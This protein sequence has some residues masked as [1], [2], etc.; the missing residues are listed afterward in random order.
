MKLNVGGVD[1]IL[2]V[3]LGVVLIAATV[4]GAL[5]VWGYI[6]VVPLVTGLVNFCPLYTVLGFSSR[7]S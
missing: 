5:P 2:R 4:M 7:K 1:K 3:V 6:G